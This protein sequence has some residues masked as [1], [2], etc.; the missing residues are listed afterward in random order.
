MILSQTYNIIKT[1]HLIKSESTEKNKYSLVRNQVEKAINW[2]LK[3]E[4]EVN[5]KS[6]YLNSQDRHYINKYLKKYYSNY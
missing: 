2:C 6:C 1:L 5:Y 4:I 3:Y